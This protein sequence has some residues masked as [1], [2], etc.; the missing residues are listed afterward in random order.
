MTT[1]ARKQPTRAG[2]AAQPPSATQPAQPSQTARSA[3]LPLAGHRRRSR[4]RIMKNRSPGVFA[5][6]SRH[7]RLRV[8]LPAVAAASH[9]RGPLPWA[10]PL[11]AAAL[12][13]ARYQHAW[14]LGPAPIPPAQQQGQ[15]SQTHAPDKTPVRGTTAR[16]PNNRQICSMTGPSPSMIRHSVPAPRL[17]ARGTRAV[18]CPRALPGAPVR[19]KTPVRGTAA[20]PPNNWQICSMMGPSQSRIRYP[21]PAPRLRRAERARLRQR[22]CALERPPPRPALH[23]SGRTGPRGGKDRGT[24]HRQLGARRRSQPSRPQRDCAETPSLEAILATGV[25]A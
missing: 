12:L 7:N 10:V 16:P 13:R 4:P 15:I 23:V 18:L 3:L 20:R 6:A 9:Q 14:A 8:Q 25:S 5:L 17:R 21:A 1:T 22:R 11:R 24:R 19:V 2:S